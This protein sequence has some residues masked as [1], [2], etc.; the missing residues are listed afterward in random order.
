M[1]KLEDKDDPSLTQL[2]FFF[3]STFLF[4]FFL[5]ASASPIL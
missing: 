1:Q 2:L 3:L 5:S 4:I